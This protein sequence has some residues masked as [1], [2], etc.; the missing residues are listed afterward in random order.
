VKISRRK[1]L[2]SDYDFCNAGKRLRHER[3]Y[4]GYFEHN[5]RALGGHH[6][7]IP[8]E[9]KRIAQALFRM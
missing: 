1:R 5:A 9:L 2:A 8:H 7:G 6:G 4:R 3:Q